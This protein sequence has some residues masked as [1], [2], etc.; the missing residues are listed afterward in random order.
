[1]ISIKICFILVRKYKL[2]FSFVYKN[3]KSEVLRWHWFNNFYWEL[4]FKFCSLTEQSV[5]AQQKQ[6]Q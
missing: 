1:M 4:F 2:F 3:K 6:N 5:G